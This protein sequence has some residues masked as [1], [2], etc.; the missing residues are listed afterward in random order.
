MLF[1][2]YVIVVIMGSKSHLK[3]K[4]GEKEGKL[5]NEFSQVLLLLAAFNGK[6]KLSKKFGLVPEI[7]E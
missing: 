4:R 3:F 2:P 5:F 7:S 1:Q 6:N